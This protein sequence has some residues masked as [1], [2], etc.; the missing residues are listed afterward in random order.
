MATR[1]WYRL[2][3]GTGPSVKIVWDNS[4]IHTMTDVMPVEAHRKA[5]AAAIEVGYEALYPGGAAY[6]S[7]GRL[8]A[9]LRKPKQI[10]ETSHVVGSDLVYASIQN[11]GG[12]IRAK[13]PG[14]RLLI[15]GDARYTEGHGGVYSP[16]T[17]DTPGRFTSQQDVIASAEEV[18]IP[19]KHYLDVIG[20]AYEEIC[21]QTLE[22]IY[23]G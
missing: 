13:T 9:D 4:K 15:H 16:G 21:M 23:P 12:T 1:R 11:T 10:T 17:V 6:R 3:T 14:G 22:Q 20:P 8:G 5:L 19:A 2:P 7:S 18:T